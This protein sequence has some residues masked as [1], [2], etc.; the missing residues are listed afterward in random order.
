MFV[1]CI[2]PI[3]IT[4]NEGRGMVTKSSKT[5]VLRENVDGSSLEVLKKCVSSKL[6][7]TLQNE[8]LL[9]VYWAF[10]I[11]EFKFC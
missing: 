7:K 3:L 8:H 9:V 1:S 4:E 5:L 2:P 6:G 11:R 10:W